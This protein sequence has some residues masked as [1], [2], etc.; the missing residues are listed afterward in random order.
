MNVKLTINNVEVQMGIEF[1]TNTV[2]GIPDAEAYES[3]FL[4]FAKS[5]SADI[6]SE[7][8]S[9][10]KIS[11]ETVLLL[12][13]DKEP[14]VLNSILSNDACNALVTTEQLIGYLEHGSS[15]VIK[16]IISNLSDYEGIDANKVIQ[17]IM[18]LDNPSYDLALAGGW[19]T[20]K[21][22]LK[23]LVRSSDKD[24]KANAEDTLR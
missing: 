11:E 17:S 7:V 8:A 18:G 13:A 22:A 4:E 12:L 16:T 15:E 21:R 5:K 20:P 23:K 9:K 14:E 1:Q 2:E 24:V 19:R 6:R 3:L 10:S